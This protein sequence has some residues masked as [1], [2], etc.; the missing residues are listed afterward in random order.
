MLDGEADA[1][2]DAVGLE[3]GELAGH[4]PLD[5]PVEADVAVVDQVHGPGDVE[6][7]VARVRVPRVLLDRDARA[8]RVRPPRHLEVEVRRRAERV[9]P[10]RG[11]DRVRVAAEEEVVVGRALLV[12]SP[13]RVAAA[14]FGGGGGSF[15]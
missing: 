6:G 5:A 4:G 12:R 15:L 10:A 2:T 13:C 7:A 8:Q 3:H 14:D 9:A 11:A 1:A